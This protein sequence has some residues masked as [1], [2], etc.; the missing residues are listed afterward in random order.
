M[1]L[2]IEH[3]LG[4]RAPAE[5]IWAVIADLDAWQAWNPLYPSAQGAL[6]IGETLTLE[7]ALP[8]EAPRTIRPT[9]VDWVPN[10][11]IHW[12]LSLLSG[13]V[14]SLRYIEIEQLAETGCIFSNGEIFRGPLGPLVAGRMRP[15]IQAGFQ[16]MGEVVKAR[17]EAAW[18][19][20]GEPTT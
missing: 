9:I 13:L 8:G 20:G 4:V 7:L 14:R 19:G 16:A 2:T 5:A 3:R 6:R 11:Q 17:A 18:R 15:A 1:P 10:E 12:R